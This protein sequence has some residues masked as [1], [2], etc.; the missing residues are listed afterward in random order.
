MRVRIASLIMLSA[1][2]AACQ[3]GAPPAGAT[4]AESPSASAPGGGSGSVAHVDGIEWFDGDI[5]A[6]FAQA[7]REGKLVFLYWG[8]EWCPPCY[9][10]KAHVFPRQ[11]F[12]RALRQFVA[13]YLDGDAP[14]AQRIAESFAVQGYPSAVVLKADRTEIARISGGSDLASY[15]QILDLALDDAQPAAD[16]LSR[17]R[18]SADS[19]LDA[20]SCRRLA[21]NDWSDAGDVPGEL[22]TALQLAAS[23]CPA[24]SRVERDR[25]TVTAADIAA[26]EEWS[27]IEAGGRPGA[28]LRSLLGAVQQM[29]A[30]PARSV[31]AGPALLYLGD[32]LLQVARK[33]LPPEHLSRLQQDYFTFL[34]A[35]EM[36]ERQSDTV[37]LLSAARRVQAAKALGGT[38]DVPAAIAAQARATLDAFLA[39]DYDANSRAGIVNSAS[40]VLY[41]LGDDARLR[42]LLEQQMK[43]SR[44]P[45]YYMPDMADIEERAGN[46]AAALQW[47]ERGYRESKGPA[48]RFQ[49][50]TQY[51]HGLLRLSPEDASRITAAVLEVTG[52]LE[53]PERIHART[54]TRVERLD[55]AL[56]DWAAANRPAAAQLCGAPQFAA[57]FNATCEGLEHL[58]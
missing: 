24:D 30:D 39:R 4:G 7:Q 56:A 1:M 19:R 20:A 54:R 43:V 44:T 2:L 14:G 23:R 35:I 15:A 3:R 38:Q 10:L 5:D 46:K 12:Q 32:E 16:V 48:T 50:G 17:L 45:Y 8:A 36:D 27:A 42:Q 52:E 53:G 58:Q 33:V 21:W 37:R 29:L 13:V 49:W 25:L 31:D 55:A 51:L 18:T 9:D 26:Q 47:L 6:A 34:D 11:D 40:W 57:R 22:V 41:E 28:S